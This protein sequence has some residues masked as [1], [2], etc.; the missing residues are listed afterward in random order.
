V[1][2]QLLAIVRQRRREGDGICGARSRWLE[3]RRVGVLIAKAV[4][5]SELFA[6]AAWGCLQYG[7]QLN[8]CDPFLRCRLTEPDNGGPP[9]SFCASGCSDA[10]DGTELMPVGV[11]NAAHTTPG[12]ELTAI[13]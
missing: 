4:L 2:E 12:S 13:I 9:K 10:V 1:R 5:P 3:L 11:E 6:P 8:S 7:V